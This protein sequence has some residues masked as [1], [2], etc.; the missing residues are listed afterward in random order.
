MSHQPL[1]GRLFE[2]GEVMIHLLTSAAPRESIYTLVLSGM[3]G[4]FGCPCYANG[5]TVF[6]ENPPNLC[7]DLDAY[8]SL[9]EYSGFVNSINYALKS[10]YIPMC[11]V[12]LIPCGAVVAAVCSRWSRE[13]EINRAIVEA[14]VI[15][16]S[17]AR[18]V[19]W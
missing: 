14:N 2:E 8:I 16:E 3:D 9:E 5:T 13:K 7:A 4:P 11:P 6:V 17:Q 1:D 15:L 19:R 10:S 12:G 18:K